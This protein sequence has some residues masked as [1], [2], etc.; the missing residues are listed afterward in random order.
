[1][2]RGSAFGAAETQSDH[3]WMESGAPLGTE[4]VLDAYSDEFELARGGDVDW[5]GENP[6]RLKDS[7]ADTL[8]IYHI[9]VPEL[10]AP[11]EAE[12]KLEVQIEDVLLQSFLDVERED[13]SVEDRKLIGRKMSQ[14]AADSDLQASAYL[15][16]RRA[17]GNPASRFVFDTAVSVKQPYAERVQTSRTDEQLDHFLL[18]V[19][20]AADE[21]QWRLDTDNWS[22]APAGAWWCSQG[23]CG[24]WD[25]CPAGG[26]L[27]KRAAEAVRN[28]A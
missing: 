2:L 11:I 6:G 28:G 17:E 20:G 8:R 26:L 15:A 9:T 5:H 4:L 18:D 25:S 23:S 3:E 24:F 22:F 10:S 27:R 7:G 19:L 12:R 1:M 14:E 21:I 16:G 13:G